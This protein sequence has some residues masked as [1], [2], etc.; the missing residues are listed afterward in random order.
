MAIICPTGFMSYRSLMRL[1]EAVAG[2]W[3]D[4]MRDA[5]R[6]HQ[7]VLSE[8]RELGKADSLHHG[9]VKNAL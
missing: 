1:K 7:T 3:L 8:T 9:N 6:A 4:T 2:V 5:A